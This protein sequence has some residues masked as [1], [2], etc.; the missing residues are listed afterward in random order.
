MAAIRLGSIRQIL[1]LGALALCIAVMHHVS[2]ASGAAHAM[3][4]DAMPVATVEASAVHTAMADAAP[5]NAGD[6]HPGMPG[7]A[8]T[9]LHLCL[10][11]LYAVGALALALLAF[12]RRSIAQL[13]VPAGPRGSPSPGRPPDRRGRLILASLCVLRI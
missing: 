2:L 5:A 6:E 8:H 3:A 11:V 9:M 1:L 7:G 12:G 13:P 4:S 10:A